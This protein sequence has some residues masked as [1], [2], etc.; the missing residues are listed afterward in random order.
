MESYLG[1]HKVAIDF[2]KSCGS[3]LCL[4]ASPIATGCVLYHRIVRKQLELKERDVDIEKY[5]LATTCLYLGAKIEEEPQKIR[6]V[7]NVAHRL[8]HQDEK[9]L[10]IGD[11]YWKLHDSVTACELIVLRYLKFQV[12]FDSPI[13]YIL[14]FCKSLEDWLPD[15]NILH[16][17]KLPQIC[18]NMVND[19][20]Y[21]PLVIFYPAE[22]VAASIVYIALEV[23]HL[24]I[25]EHKEGKR[26]FQVLCP[27]I[28][29]NKLKDIGCKILTLYDHIKVK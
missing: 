5:L 23:T 1:D 28:K 13:K 14:M 18:W 3:H 16:Q 25:P 15:S 6:D 9:A 12:T 2:I 29:E 19:L 26:W 21:L 27:G 20:C 7:I 10:E 17:S 8:L 11:D 22:V 4:S 24:E